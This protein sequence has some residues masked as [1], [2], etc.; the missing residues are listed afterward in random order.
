MAHL[1]IN[2]IFI[3]A[4]CARIPIAFCPP[5]LVGG[6]FAPGESMFWHFPRDVSMMS[7]SMYFPGCI[8]TSPSYK[9]QTITMSGPRCPLVEFF[10]KTRGL[11]KT[12]SWNTPNHWTIEDLIE[13]HGSGGPQFQETLPCFGIRLNPSTGFPKG[14]C[15]CP[16]ISGE[17]T[18]NC[19]PQNLSQ[20]NEIQC[21]M[22]PRCSMV[23][24]YL[25]TWLGHF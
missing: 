23:L 4:R 2:M 8:H 22:K 9:M 1:V 13:S 21:F 14:Q 16:S 6:G 3:W 7:F 25:P 24:E 10:Q 5:A 15:H 11:P 12:A 20:R 17:I 19:L 18:V